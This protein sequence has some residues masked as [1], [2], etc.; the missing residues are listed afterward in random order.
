MLPND[1]ACIL[2]KMV[3]SHTCSECNT[4]FSS[5]YNLNRHRKRYH[6]YDSDDQ[7]KDDSEY[8][9]ENECVSKRHKKSYHNE[10]DFDSKSTSESNVSDDDDEEEEDNISASDNESV[11]ENMNE[12]VASNKDSSSSEDQESDNDSDSQSMDEND[13][14]DDIFDEENENY[15]YEHLIQDVLIKYENEF[16]VL[17]QQY[18]E[19]G[20]SKRDAAAEAFKCLRPQYKKMLRKTIVRYISDMIATR[21]TPLFQSILK[22]MRYFEEDGLDE[23][24]AIKSAVSYRKYSIYSLLNS[25]IKDLLRKEEEENSD[26]EYD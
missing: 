19:S 9:D 21:R 5:P 14:S 13:A 11:S 1:Y 4:T 24:E 8:E 12:S 10:N 26:I 23:K 3:K 2:T 6:E 15:P 20:L 16:G 25:Y 7:D 22:K 17:L 18:K